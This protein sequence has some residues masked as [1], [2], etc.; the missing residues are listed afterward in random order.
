MN[1]HIIFSMIF[2]IILKI[3]DTKHMLNAL[4]Q[5]TNYINDWMN[6][7]MFEIQQS[8]S[9]LSANYLPCHY[10]DSTNITDGII[11]SNGSVI[12]DFME[13]PIGTYANVTYKIENKLIKPFPGC[14][15]KEN[16]Y[17]YNLVSSY[18]RGCVCNRKPCIRF[19]C[20][21]PYQIFANGKCVNGNDKNVQLPILNKMGKQFSGYLKEHFYYVNRKTCSEPTM[22]N[23]VLI[24]VVQII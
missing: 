4:N 13:F 5:S 17:K 2:I 15:Y 12:F 24:D 14:N 22:T 18:R 23:N 10:F 3:N 8:K 9:I 21:K 11:Y 16:Y 19:C 20:K 6:F 7:T 1:F